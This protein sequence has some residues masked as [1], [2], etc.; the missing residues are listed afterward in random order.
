L[1]YGLMLAQLEGSKS[2]TALKNITISKASVLLNKTT[3]P[4]VKAKAPL[5]KAVIE[6][7]FWEVVDI[8]NFEKIRTGLRDLMKFVESNEQ[9]LTANQIVFVNKV[10]DYIEQN[11]YVEDVQELIKPPFD[12]PQSFIKLFDAE[13][14]KKFVHIINEVKENATRVVG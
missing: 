10:I 1:M 9:N 2:F 11:G 8:L 13:K 7:E 6:D 4:Q 12:K 14:Q 3:I 5:L